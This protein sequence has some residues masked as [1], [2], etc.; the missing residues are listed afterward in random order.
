MCNNCNCD[1]YDRCSIVGHITSPF[2]CCEK[3][4]LYDEAHTCLKMNSKRKDSGE[5]KKYP[6][7]KIRPITTIIENG[8]LKVVVEQNGEEFPL[9]IDI[10]KQLSAR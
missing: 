4:D 3:C 9:Y 2:H 5:E 8:I 7:P 6:L 1:F 10:E